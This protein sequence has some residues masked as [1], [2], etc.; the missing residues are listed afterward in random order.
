MDFASLGLG[1]F[2]RQSL[3]EDTVEYYIHLIP[4]ATSKTPL[5]DTK[6]ELEKLLP[7]I[8]KAVEPFTNDFIWQ[9]DEFN[10]KVVEKDGVAYLQGRIEFGESIDDEWFT[11]FLLREISKKFSQLWIH[12]VDTD[13]EF[14][15]IEAAH[16]LPKWLSPEVAD[17]RVWIT[18][19]SLR[20][21]PRSKEDR[22]AA[23]AGQLRS[24]G[25]KD[26]LNFLE[27]FQ[28]DL[29]HIQIVQEEAFYRISE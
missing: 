22:A 2:P 4:S 17:N 8:L 12:V 14:L 28:K 21:I 11:V 27:K 5:K 23:K 25:I 19:G 18:N 3:V 13:G 7:D 26:A 29:L 10:L 24:L 6:S 1:S 16:A 9:R 20:I 15:L